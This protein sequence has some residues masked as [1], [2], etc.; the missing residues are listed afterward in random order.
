MEFSPE[1]KAALTALSLGL[2]A[3]PVA[4]AAATRLRDAPS[5]ETTTPPVGAPPVVSL[6]SVPITSVP[7]GA[8][9]MV[10]ATAAAGSSSISKVEFVVDGVVAFTSAAPPFSHAFTWT[11]AGVHTVQ[12]RATAADGLVGSSAV[13]SIT[14]LPVMAPPVGALLPIQVLPKLGAKASQLATSDGL[15]FIGRGTNYAYH[16]FAYSYPGDTQMPAVNKWAQANAAQIAKFFADKGVNFV[17]LPVNN[18][19]DDA[20]VATVKIVCDA[21]AAAGIRTMLVAF[22]GIGSTPNAAAGQLLATLWSKLGK[23]VH[24]L[25]NVINEPHQ[26]DDATWQSGNL[27]ALGPIRAAGYTQPVFMDGQNW[28]WSLPVAAARAIVAR[29]PQCVFMSHRYAFDGSAIRPA[30]DAKA[31]AAE[32]RAAPDLCKGVGEFGWFNGGGNSTSIG[33]WCQAMVDETNAAVAAGDISVSLSWTTDWDQN[34]QISATGPPP[35]E[36]SS[37]NR[38]WYAISRGAPWELNAWGKV[39]AAAWMA[40]AV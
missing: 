13:L 22:G 29:D 8:P 33:S 12:A 27:A 39:A 28:A 1:Q 3:H 10:T 6:V 31:W 19:T 14:V 16:V 7:A 20:F 26:I 38:D 36:P 17:R 21:N 11:T 40:G 32:W 30:S 23:P 5:G 2:G 9:V 4:A 25:L 34:S 35:G 37:S 15:R 18:Q 24:V